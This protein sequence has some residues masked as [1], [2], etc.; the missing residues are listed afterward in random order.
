MSYTEAELGRGTE[1]QLPLPN[2]LHPHALEERLVALALALVD[3][4]HAIRPY[5][6]SA[7]QPVDTSPA[8]ACEAGDGVVR[9]LADS[10]QS[11]ITQ[12]AERGPVL[13]QIPVLV[14]F[15]VGEREPLERKRSGRDQRSSQRLV[16]LD[17]ASLVF[18]P[19][20][21]PKRPVPED[22][23]EHGGSLGVP[24][25]T[26]HLGRPH[27]GRGCA[28]AASSTRQPEGDPLPHE[29]PCG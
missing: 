28:L 14:A 27:P 8:V 4:A 3:P 18:L 11:H 22:I 24:T 6:D 19:R 23:G 12:L 5:R 13:N 25:V 20:G 29:Q 7:G 1:H 17:Q 16:E 9:S 21:R 15:A 2:R 10:P 26:W